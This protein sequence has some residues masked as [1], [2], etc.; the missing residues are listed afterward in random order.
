MTAVKYSNVLN[1]YLPNRRDYGLL[2]LCIAAAG[3][4]HHPTLS[5]HQLHRPLNLSFKF[6]RVFLCPPR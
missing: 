1:F 3:R 4:A 6:H 5:R 2:P